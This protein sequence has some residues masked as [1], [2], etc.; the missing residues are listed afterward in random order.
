[1]GRAHDPGVRLV[2]ALD[3]VDESAASGE[4]GGVFPPWDARPD[5]G[6]ESAGHIVVLLAS[7]T[8]H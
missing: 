3:I 7:V 8:D 1:M 6:D 2:S 5:G 4:Q